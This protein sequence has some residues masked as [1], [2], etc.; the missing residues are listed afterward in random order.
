MANNN[1]KAILNELYPTVANHLKSPSNEKRLMM[2]VGGFVD[3]HMEQ[4][5]TSGPCYRIVITDRD[6]NEFYEALGVSEERVKEVIKHSSYISNSWAIMSNPIYSGCAVAIRYFIVNN[7]KENVKLLSFFLCVSMYPLI[8]HKYFKYNCNEN[9]MN[10]TISHLSNKYKYKQLKSLYNVLQDL[11]F[12]CTTTHEAKLKTGADI[13]FT[14]YINDMH[15]RLNDN[16][17][18]VAVEYYKNHESG[19]YL[20]VDEDNNDPDNFRETDNSSYAVERIVNNV[21]TKVAM[22][23]IN[24]RLVTLSAK[25]CDVSVNELR[26]SVY[27]ITSEE[28]LPE[29]KRMIEYM[30]Q[31]YLF[32]MHRSVDLIKSKDYLITML[33]IYKR[34][35]VKDTNLNGIRSLIDAWMAQS[36]ASK[37][38]TRKA[39][40]SSFKK[41]MYVFVALT[42]QDNM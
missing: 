2:T 6:K 40:I 25:I 11:S 33:D 42:I 20:N 38:I 13:D 21:T 22:Q 9:I 32:D 41:A 29:F 3:R 26:N 16:L 7:K 14:K 37:K 36:P 1:D 28:H 8:H 15:A 10:Y 19:N 34:T 12:V 27:M 17:K 23:G 30:M 35:N 5:S 4:L 24:L 18:N 31:I 39:S